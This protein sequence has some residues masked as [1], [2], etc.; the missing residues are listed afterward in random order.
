MA[1]TTQTTAHEHWGSRLAFVLAAVGSA[2]GLGN[3]WK[4]PYITGENGGGAFVV[5][6]LACIALIGLPILIAEILLGR[7]GRMSPINAVSATARR[8]GR[9]PAWAGVGLLGMAGSFVI[10]SFYSVIAGWALAYVGRTATGTFAGADAA[11]VKAAFDALKASPWQLVLWHTAFMALTAVVVGR[12][13]RHGLER[14]AKILMPGLALLLVILIGYAATTS[15]FSAGVDFLFTP[16]FSKLSTHSVLIALGH[17]FFTLSLGM[18][19]MIAYGSYLAPGTSIAGTALSVVVLDTVI[20]LMAGTA[21]F[22]VVF[23]NGLEPAVGPGLIFQTLPLAF[24]SMPGGALFGALFFLLLTFAAWTSTIS[25][26]EPTVEWLQERGQGRWPATIKAAV[27]IWALG[28]A[29]AL[30]FNVWSGYTVFGQNLFGA[31]DFLTANVMLPLTGL[32]VALFVGWGMST[33]SASEELGLG[34]TL[35]FRL[36]HLAIR[37]VAPV[38]VVVVFVYNLL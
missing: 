30:S 3:V 12:G 2:V 34:E 17:A 7:R 10:L 19:I 13:V 38:A 5:V 9:S 23:A 14:A 24:G 33:A 22:P 18:G 15:G 1:G 36:W 31:L 21:I 26:L 35:G 11:T 4:F 16:D 6:Y 32:G 25:L 37:F 27:T 8:E 29:S 20:A 28:V